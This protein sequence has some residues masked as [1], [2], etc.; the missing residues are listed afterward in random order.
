MKKKSKDL[1]PRAGGQWSE[2]R[3]WSFVRSNLRRAQWPPIY[4]AKKLAERPYKGDNKRQKFEYQCAVCKN[5]F[6]GKEVQVDHI[7]PCGSLKKYEDLPQFV[8]TLYCEVDNLRVL[9]Y[10]CHQKVT[11]EERNNTKVS[12]TNSKPSRRIKKP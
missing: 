1:K 8:K 4:Q 9:C 2:A 12:A 3:F 7:K 10:D 5:W 6:M 11:N